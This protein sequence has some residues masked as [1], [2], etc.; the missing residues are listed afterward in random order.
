MLLFNYY[1]KRVNQISLAWLADVTKSGGRKPE[2][3]MI[4]LNEKGEALSIAP[5]AVSKAITERTMLRAM[6][7][8]AEALGRITDE[9]TWKKIAAL[10]SSESILDE[11]SISLMRKQ[12]PELTAKVFSNLLTGFQQSVALDTVRNE[13]ELHTR[14]LGWLNNY[15]MGKDVDKF[16][17]RVYA[18]LFKTPKTDPWLGLLMPDAYTAID[19]SGVVKK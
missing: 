16:N 10:H 2:G 7:A 17:E 15:S 8:G 4:Q 5:L 9:D 6:T 13:Y 3:V 11:R 18:D 14:L 12:N 1:N 19:N